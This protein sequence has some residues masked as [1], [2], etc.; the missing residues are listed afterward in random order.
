M[1]EN[2]MEEKTN[3][4]EVEAVVESFFADDDVVEDNTQSFVEP[5]NETEPD[6]VEDKKVNTNTIKIKYNGE[7]EELDLESQYEDIVALIQKGKNYDHVL[8]E[9][10]SL[11]NSPELEQLKEIANQ[12]GVKDVGGLVAKL[13]ADIHEGKVNERVKELIDEGMS[14]IHA[15]KMAELELKQEPKEVKP[16][17]P[18]DQP[19]QDDDLEA[20]KR[21]FVELFEEYPDLVKTKYEDYPDSVKEMIEQGKTPLVAYQKYMLEETKSEKAKLEHEQNVKKRNVGSLKSSK[22]DN[23]DDFLSMFNQD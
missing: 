4:P 6:V 16:Q 7:D 5:S 12:V 18:E 9:R 19:N 10:D 20:Q 11:K 15:R 21:L 8:S 14:D 22:A 2:T 1:K 17:Q 13:K 23:S 3:Q